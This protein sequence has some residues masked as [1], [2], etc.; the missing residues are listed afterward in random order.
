MEASNCTFVHMAKKN[1]SIESICPGLLLEDIH[2]ESL[3]RLW[4]HWATSFLAAILIGCITINTLGKF[5]TIYYIKKRAPNRP[6]NDMIFIDQCLQLLPSILHG[7]MVITSVVAKKPLV[8]IIGNY[9]CIGMFLNVQFH[10]VVF[11]VGGAGMAFYRFMIYM[12][13]STIA[14]L[15]KTKF[16]VLKIQS[17]IGCILVVLGTIGFFFE[18]FDKPLDFC[19]GYSRTMYTILADY[20]QGYQ[21]YQSLVTITNLSLLICLAIII[22]EFICYFVIMFS[23]FK[24]DIKM[25]TDKVIDTNVMKQRNKK[26]AITMTGQFISF[27]VEIGYAILLLFL[28]NKKES[29]II[30]DLETWILVIFV[31]TVI[32]V[33]QIGTSPVIRRTIRQLCIRQVQVDIVP[34]SVD[35]GQLLHALKLESSQ[36]D[37]PQE[38]SNNDVEIHL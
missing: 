25:A 23:V 38:M 32:T 7:A 6:L 9:G 22:F 24:H 37:D 36:V 2:D 19:R 4:N 31:W 13:Y 30:K 3:A 28:Y 34:N 27:L 21:H 29:W 35:L 33:I 10:N 26:N 15:Q 14:D 12:F 8:S 17:V 16:L 11:I 1:S 5:L 18:N 20:H